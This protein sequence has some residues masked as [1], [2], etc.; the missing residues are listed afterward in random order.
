MSQEALPSMKRNE[1]APENQKD[2]ASKRKKWALYGLIGLVA[3]GLGI[4]GYWWFF[5]RGRV[6]TDDAYVVVDIATISSRVRGTVSQVL[7]DNDQFVKEGQVLLRLDPRDYRVAVDKA[8]G[9]LAQMEAEV[10]S[11]SVDLHL[12]D[13]QTNDRVLAAEAGLKAAK[14]QVE[15]EKNRLNRLQKERH[16]AQADLDYAQKELK[17]YETLYRR[18]SVSEE[19]RD[20]ALKRFDDAKAAL[21]ALNDRI[22]GSK[23]AIKTAREQARQSEARLKIAKSD[24]KKVDIQAQRQK[25]L[26]ARRNQARAAL[27]QARLNLSYCTIQAPLAG[28]VAQRDVQVG[29]RILPGEPVMAVVPLKAAYVEAN[30]K[31]TQLKNVRRGQPATIKADIYPS[32]TYHGRVAGIAAGTGAAFSLLPPENATGNWVKVVRRVPVRILLDQPPPSDHPLRAGLSLEVTIETD[33]ENGDAS[34][35]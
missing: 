16:S 29:D 27:E 17:R 4:G 25:S 22:A 8:K 35:D 5:L 13:S 3:V 15:V 11:A 33:G 10:Q 34:K 2:N 21:G 24:R 20:R 32:H 7:V 14:Y 31:E 28:A 19:Q 30:F 12:I 9:V 1:D 6:S 18:R 26:K 23:A